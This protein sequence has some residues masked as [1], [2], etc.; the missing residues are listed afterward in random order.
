MY[1]FVLVKKTGVGKVYA[2]IKK[3]PRQPSGG[4]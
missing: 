1:G 4:L 2:K 3:I